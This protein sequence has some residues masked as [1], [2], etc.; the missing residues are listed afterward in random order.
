MLL[1]LKKKIIKYRNILVAIKTYVLIN[2]QIHR[3][4]FV[5]YI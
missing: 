1:K 4:L 3:E 2:L 5:V